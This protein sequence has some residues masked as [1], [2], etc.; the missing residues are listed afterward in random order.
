MFCYT[1]QSTYLNAALR[2]KNSVALRGDDWFGKF[3][4]HTDGQQQQLISSSSLTF[5][6]VLYLLLSL[7]KQRKIPKDLVCV[8]F[9]EV[10]L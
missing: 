2:E 3:R 4:L 6:R 1:L 5:V 10:P 7:D 9:Q 8:S